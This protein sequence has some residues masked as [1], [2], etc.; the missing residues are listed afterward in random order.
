M[1]WNSTR[2][3]NKGYRSFDLRTS[4]YFDA[5]CGHCPD[6]QSQRSNSVA[7]RIQ[8]EINAH[9][10]AL[11]F[12]L[13]LTYSEEFQ[14]YLQFYD[15]DGDIHTLRVWNKTHVQRFFKV[16][17]RQLE[18]YFGNPMVKF[19]CVCER[20]SDM[21]YL[22]DSG[23]WRVAMEKPHYHILCILYGSMDTY[24][25]RSL[26]AA[27]Y[28]YCI[29]ENVNSSLRS[30]MHYLFSS[31]WYYGNVEDLEVNRSPASCS[32]YIAKYCC[33]QDGDKI[34]GIDIDHIHSLVDPDFSIKNDVS[35]AHYSYLDAM[36]DDYIDLPLLPDD[37]DEAS[38][39][40]NFDTQRIFNQEKARLVKSCC[41]KFPKPVE[42]SSLL[43]ISFSSTELGMSFIYDKTYD[44]LVNIFSGNQP[45]TLSGSR[46]TSSILLPGYYFNKL[47]K[48]T[49]DIPDDARFN[50]YDGKRF[51]YHVADRFL[52]K[53]K[54]WNNVEGLHFVYR[55]SSITK[56][57]YTGFGN[58][59][60]SKQYVAR[61]SRLADRILQ[62]L[63]DP[64]YF[65][66]YEK[67]YDKY[68]ISQYQPMPC[69]F[70]L[71]GITKV[72]LI[73]YLRRYLHFDYRQL[74][75]LPAIYKEIQSVLRY[76]KFCRDI[77]NQLVHEAY[78][79][80]YKARFSSVAQRDPDLF[81]PHFI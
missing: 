77:R 71:K 37:P 9:P 15:T 60:K 46:S 17:R 5:P 8:S 47:C 42:F 49:V 63:S 16:V 13:T 35:F 45:L 30:F 4:Q 48:Y 23:R 69:I 44:E 33:K 81:L 27:F 38:Y 65:E 50:R 70:F 68:I 41:R 24:P 80:L 51:T 11:V 19:M 74:A 56:S 66:Y 12:F 53:V 20:G 6:C 67:R 54:I 7:F 1:C 2:L 34:F 10:D 64:V 39:A 21:F 3:L 26:P 29:K 18:Y 31:R 36:H 75:R 57:F 73:R 52:R 14:P 58:Y 55:I 40:S 76:F 61:L 59:I 25:I 72:N 22:A 43:P 79:R 62:Y 78:V 28:Q 32:R